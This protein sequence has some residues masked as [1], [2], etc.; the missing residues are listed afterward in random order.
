LSI[1]EIPQGGDHLLEGCLDMF[2]HGEGLVLEDRW[3]G[4]RVKRLSTLFLFGQ[5]AIGFSF[6]QKEMVVIVVLEQE[7]LKEKKKVPATLARIIAR[8][9]LESSVS[10]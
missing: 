2:G 9:S 4:T 3:N 8:P 1:H 5:E 10:S 7:S 6:F